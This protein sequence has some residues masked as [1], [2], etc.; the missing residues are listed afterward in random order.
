MDTWAT[1]GS[2]F[3]VGGKPLAGYAAIRMKPQQ[4]LQGTVKPA[5]AQ[6]AEIIAI[7]AAI[8]QAHKEVMT[9]ITTDSEWVLRALIDW[10]PIWIQRE[11]KTGDDKPVTHGQHLKYIWDLAI[12]RP[13]KIKLCKIKAHS[14]Q[15]SVHIN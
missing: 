6:L 4:V 15:K 8:E 10:M 3:Y 5:S 14:K 1:D 13:D 7:A 12:K 2:S 9:V 11:M